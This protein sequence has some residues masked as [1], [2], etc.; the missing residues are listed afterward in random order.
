MRV[1]CLL[2]CVWGVGALPVLIFSGIPL[3]LEDR[4]RT[5]KTEMCV[6]TKGMFSLNTH[7]HT[8]LFLKARHS[9]GA[10]LLLAYNQTVQ[11]AT[12]QI[13]LLPC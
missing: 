7:K 11:Q 12:K 4:N 3:F 13:H 1:T 2:V 10:F 8:L 9:Q 6:L 5:G